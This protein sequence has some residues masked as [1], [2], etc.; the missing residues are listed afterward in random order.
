[1]TFGIP[2][3]RSTVFAIIALT[4]A[5]LGMA[6]AVFADE[7]ATL[8]S[9]EDVLV[10]QKDLERFVELQVPEE[11]QRFFWSDEEQIRRAIGQLFLVRKAASDARAQGLSAK[12]QWAEAYA[13]DRALFQRQIE[14]RVESRLANVDL[15]EAAREAYLAH[16]D[17]FVSPEQ[18]RASHILIAADNRS[19]QEARDIAVRVLAKLK[20][21]PDRFTE[22]AVK[23]SDDPSVKE[24]KGDLGFFGRGQM[25][26]SFEE[27]VFAMKRVGEIVGPVK[28]KFGYH[29]IRLEE[30]R[31]SRKRGFEEVKTELVKKGKAK[32]RS[33]V[34]E[35]YVEG[36]R[37]LEGIESDQGAIESLVDP[38]PTPSAPNSSHQD[39]VSEG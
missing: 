39:P 31:E 9:H 24:N 27:A 20:A 14:K 34:R 26:K 13:A 1:M 3:S 37:S 17:R 29:I 10:S 35:E 22:L 12:V 2:E 30:R 25:V 36:L 6:G 4:G 8:V 15:E 7:A 33:R 16:P 18:V 5:A 38:L 23:E 11:K 19:D 28:S 32:L 21:A